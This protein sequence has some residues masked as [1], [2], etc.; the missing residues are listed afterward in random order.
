VSYPLVPRR[1]A[2]PP[3]PLHAGARRHYEEAGV[4]EGDGDPGAS[5]DAAPAGV[6]GHAPAARQA[7]VAK[8]SA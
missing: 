6:P 8:E 1:M 2:R 4:L 3:I 7:A 5:A